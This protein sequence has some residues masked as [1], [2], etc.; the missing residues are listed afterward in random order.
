MIVFLA[1][2]L[3]VSLAALGP[4]GRSFIAWTLAVIGFDVIR[5]RRKMVLQNIGRAFG[6]DANPNVCVGIG[7]ASLANFILTTLEFFSARIVFPQQQVEF[8]NPERM[9]EALGRGRGV[10]LMGIHMGNFELMGSAVGKN[11]ALVHAP[12]KPIGKG[13]LAL[14]V[15][16]RREKNGIVEIVNERGKG[17]SRTARLLDGLRKNEVV[18]FMVDQRRSKGTLLPFFGEPAWTNTSLIALWKQYEAPILPVTVARRGYNRFQVI[19][20]DE[21]KIET[22]SLWTADE[23][24]RTNGQRMNQVVEQMIVANPKEYFWMHDRWKK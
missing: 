23:F 20:H 17:T 22:N 24:I 10:Y 19:F 12:V 6:R 21:F 11:F 9:N 1:E 7:R 16:A 15:K 18:G 13:K 5:L 3:G 8:I 2:A 4:R 14:W